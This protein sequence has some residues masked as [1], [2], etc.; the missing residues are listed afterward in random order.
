M[1]DDS[2]LQVNGVNSTSED[3]VYEFSHS[4]DRLLPVRKPKNQV[5]A[6]IVELGASLNPTQLYHLAQP[7][8]ALIWLINDLV[9]KATNKP[10]AVIFNVFVSTDLPPL[11]KGD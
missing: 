3:F 8:T 6:S 1:I 4:L 10:R 2:F 9:F 5:I 7:S 11:K